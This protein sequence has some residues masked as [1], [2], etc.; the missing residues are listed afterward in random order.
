MKMEK[1]KIVSVARVMHN[2]K[3]VDNLNHME[4][5]TLHN[6]KFMFKAQYAGLGEY[7]DNPEFECVSGKG[8]LPRGKYKIG[9]PSSIHTRASIR[10]A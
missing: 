6:G 2:I 9:H 10:R 1:V 5:V 4:N 8:P 7:K 3:T